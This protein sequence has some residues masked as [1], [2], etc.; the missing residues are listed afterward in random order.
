MNTAGTIFGRQPVVWLGLFAT[1]AMTIVQALSGQP[2]VVDGQPLQTAANVA[3]IVA[4]IIISFI[5]QYFVTPT[6]Q[7][8]LPEGTTVTTPEG[9]TAS[10]VI[11]APAAQPAPA[12]DALVGR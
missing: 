6:G 10:V 8:V 11:S 5:Q 12:G 9:S 1:L 2:L 7:P 4:P 3:K